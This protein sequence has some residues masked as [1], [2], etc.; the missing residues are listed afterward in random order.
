[1]QYLITAFLKKEEVE[2]RQCNFREEKRE[3]VGTYFPSLAN[4]GKDPKRVIV[5]PSVPLTVYGIGHELGD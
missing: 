4:K 2:Q 1:M 5:D 3:N